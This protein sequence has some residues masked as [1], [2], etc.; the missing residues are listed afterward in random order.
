MRTFL[1]ALFPAIALAY[2][3]FNKTNA[4]V[5]PKKV[6]NA[7]TIFPEPVHPLSYPPDSWSWFLQHLPAENKPIVDYRGNQIEDQDK[8][9]AILTFDVGNTDLQQCADA[10][11]RLR[12][13]YLYSQKKYTEIGFHFNSGIFYSWTDYCKGIRPVFRNRQQVLVNTQT[14]SDMSHASLRKWL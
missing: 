7:K 5:Q 3:A 13:E 10:L 6:A 11:I 9:F 2:I 1:C 12:S 14:A 4:C 8:H